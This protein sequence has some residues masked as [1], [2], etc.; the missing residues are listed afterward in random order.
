MFLFL[1]ILSP[2]LFLWAVQ[3]RLCL[4]RSEVRKARR[5]Y[6]FAYRHIGAIRRYLCI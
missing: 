4:H 1:A 2:F 5:A 3:A 6:P